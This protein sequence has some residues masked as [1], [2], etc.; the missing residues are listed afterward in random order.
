M[1]CA[2]INFFDTSPYYGDLRSET[3]LGRALK[4]LP[5]D[6]IYVATKVLPGHLGAPATRGVVLEVLPQVAA[7]V[8]NPP[9]PPRCCAFPKSYSAVHLFTCECLTLHAGMQVKHFLLVVSAQGALRRCRWA[10]TA[11]RRRTLTSARSA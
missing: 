6:Q 7:P 2:G 10:A 8:W 11:W 4:G 9:L 5:R 3:V 1:C